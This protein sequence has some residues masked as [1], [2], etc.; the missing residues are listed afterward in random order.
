MLHAGL[1]TVLSLLR[2]NLWL[3]KEDVGSNVSSGDVYLA[4]D[5]ESDL[6]NRTMGSLPE[7]R[8]STS[9]P[10]VHTDFA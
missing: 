8:V 10:V 6:A 5:S 2:Q 9:L 3:T 4:R 1:E 7:E